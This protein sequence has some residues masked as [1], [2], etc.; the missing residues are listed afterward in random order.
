MAR[1]KLCICEVLENWPEFSV[2]IFEVLVKLVFGSL[3]LGVGAI[4]G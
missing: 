1:E 4:A 3:V 2:A